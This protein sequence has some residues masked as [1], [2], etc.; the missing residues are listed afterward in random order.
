MD[1]TYD[2]LIQNH[3]SIQGKQSLSILSSF[4]SQII[5]GFSMY[6]TFTL[7]F[8]NV[9]TSKTFPIKII[10][11]LHRINLGF[12]VNWVREVLHP[13]TF[14]NGIN[15]SSNTFLKKIFW[16]CLVTYKL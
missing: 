3:S 7:C 4:P 10:T 15:S 13:S 5:F 9:S 12:R 11:K 2:T 1:S 16:V 14:M 6:T 8:S